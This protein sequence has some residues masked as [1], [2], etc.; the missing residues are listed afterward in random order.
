MEACVA[1]SANSWIANFD[2]EACTGASVAIYAGVTWSSFHEKR[3]AH[4]ADAG[5]PA[6]KTEVD[7]C[8]NEEYGAY[9]ARTDTRAYRQVCTYRT[10]QPDPKVDK[11]DCTGEN[12]WISDTT[13]SIVA[14]PTMP[15]AW[16]FPGTHMRP[17]VDVALVTGIYDCVDAYASEDTVADVYDMSSERELP[18]CERGNAIGSASTIAF[19]PER[20][21]GIESGQDGAGLDDE[22]VLR[23]L[24]VDAV[25]GLPSPQVRILQMSDLDARGQ[26]ALRTALRV[27]VLAVHDANWHDSLAGR[28]PSDSLVGLEATM[29]AQL[30]SILDANLGAD[31]TI[32]AQSLPGSAMPSTCVE[33]S[34][35]PGMPEIPCRVGELEACLATPFCLYAAVRNDPLCLP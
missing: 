24:D 8:H 13:S 5:W 4:A 20:N 16:Q 33:T 6:P 22:G 19:T 7:E 31:M 12:N 21:A 34:C 29:R 3:E 35:E 1:I 14:N 10:E 28:K 30:V 11:K 32:R 27:K 17:C 18:S 23:I 2:G 15:A 25:D 9:N 26:D